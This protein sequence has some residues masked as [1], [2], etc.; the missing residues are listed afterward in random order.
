MDRN[1]KAL[2]VHGK[3]LA[4]SGA[5]TYDKAMLSTST[6]LA[7]KLKTALA[8]KSMS[9]TAFAEKCG[10][11]KQAVQGWV[12]TGR[13]DKGHIAKFVDILDKPLEWWLDVDAA[14]AQSSIG[15]RETSRTE[16]K[17]NRWPFLSVSQREYERLDERQMGMVEGYI[18]GLLAESP[19]NKRNGTDGGL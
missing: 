18:K 7:A 1:S 19:R 13:I 4:D 5:E 3:A 14:P 6:R 11:S 9:Q 2:L 8:E 16:Y 12:K 10:V 15:V 17:L